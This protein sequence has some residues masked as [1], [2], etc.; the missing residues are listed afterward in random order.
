MTISQLDKELKQIIDEH[1]V[2]GAECI[3]NAL[4]RA[5]E[6]K[7]YLDEYALHLLLKL[8]V[9]HEKMFRECVSGKDDDKYLFLKSKGGSLYGKICE[10]ENQDI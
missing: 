7:Q 8:S 4:V 3:I 5:C 9:E 1:S 6:G 2:Y 10:T